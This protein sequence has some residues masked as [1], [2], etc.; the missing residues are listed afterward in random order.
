MLGKL[1]K[2]EFRATALFCGLLFAGLIVLAGLSRLFMLLERQLELFSL[3]LGITLGLYGVF[4][5]AS[6]TV[7]YVIIVRRFYVNVYGD[8]GYLTLTL[9]VRRSYIILSKL[10]VGF[11]WLVAQIVAIIL[12]L[13][14]LAVSPQFINMLWEVL[15]MLELVALRFATIL[16]MPVGLMIS[17]LAV[18]LV[19]SFI[20]TI[21][22]LY[23]SVSIGQLF[24]R[25]RL[26][27][28]VISYMLIGALVKII[29]QIYWTIIGLS[30]NL[31]GMIQDIFIHG[32]TL[33]NISAFSVQV[34]I[35]LYIVIYIAVT[36]GC[37]L[38]T[39]FIMRHAVN[40]Q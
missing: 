25:H 4:A 36:L 10:I 16:N 33:D 24:T 17:E 13:L 20:Y 26:I 7:V 39:H 18:L 2:H 15:A 40:L 30:Q 32:S 12:S 37:Y 22:M 19:I 34:D 38:V 35:I 29:F 23:A 21:L 31:V 9:P 5:F 27:G 11:C 28:S 8:E 1:I 14:I 6:M 3:P